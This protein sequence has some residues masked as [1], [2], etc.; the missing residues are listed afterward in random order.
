VGSLAG[1]ATGAER[2]RYYHY[3]LDLD[4][5]LAGALDMRMRLAARPDATAAV[6]EVD[7]GR[8]DLRRW[9]AAAAPGP[10]LL[11]LRGVLVSYARVFDRVAAELLGRGD[12]LQPP[13]EEELDELVGCEIAWQA[14]EPLRLAI[15]D[16]AFAERIRAWPQIAHALL[17]R[18][19]RHVHG[20]AIQRAIA[21][22]PRLEVRLVLLLW[23]LAS[24]FGRVERGGVRLP[25]PLTHQLLGRLVG[26]ERP[27]VTHAL[28]RLASAAL[29]SGQDHEWHLLGTL[30]EHL[31]V[32]GARP[33]D[34]LGQLL[35]PAAARAQR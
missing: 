19:E 7:P 18:A 30:E 34:H 26:A 17:R 11:V 27:S 8:I 2:R 6:L 20:L 25:L 28:G 21:A 12:L 10:G 14:I 15:L 3:L 33:A 16:A 31:E 9:L 23:H 29:V 1:A 22:Q 35:P 32:L 4:P 24:R 13:G 5:D